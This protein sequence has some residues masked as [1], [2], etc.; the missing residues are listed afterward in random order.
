MSKLPVVASIFAA[1][2]LLQGC[3]IVT[4]SDWEKGRAEYDGQEV[5]R[6]NRNKIAALPMQ[7]SVTEVKQRLG[8]PDFTDRW[9]H[10]DG[11]YQVL[12]YRT[13]R[14]HADGMTTRDECTPIVFVDNEL[15]GT[16]DLALDNVKKSR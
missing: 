11:E 6:D 10:D 14:T 15:K 2:L 8:T 3:V 13:H 9:Q 4:E 5:E 7:L 1:S 16:G 12:Y